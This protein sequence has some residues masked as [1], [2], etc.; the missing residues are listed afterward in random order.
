MSNNIKSMLNCLEKS[1]I[2]NW[3]ITFISK[4]A[5]LDSDSPSKVDAVVDWNCYILRIRTT[6]YD[7]GY[8]IG[9]E[10]TTYNQIRHINKNTETDSIR[11]SDIG[12]TLR[13]F[14]DNYQNFSVYNKII[15]YLKKLKWQVGHPTYGYYPSYIY[16][17][18]V[19]AND[20]ESEYT[21]VSHMPSER[22]PYLIGYG[23]KSERIGKRIIYNKPIF[24]D[25]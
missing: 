14:L 2:D 19:N 13:N 9:Y 1:I 11:N 17:F 23:F 6:P 12:M 24:D 10:T 21:H 7:I 5:F 18:I 8:H 22:L 3:S 16:M 20:G 25:L 15:S 4:D